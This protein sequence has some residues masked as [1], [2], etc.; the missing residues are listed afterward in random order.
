MPSEPKWLRNL[1]GHEY[2]DLP[3]SLSLRQTEVENADLKHLRGLRH[4][5][6]LQLERTRIGDPG[7]THIGRV[8]SLRELDLSETRITDTG[9]SHVRGL[10]HLRELDLDGTA[11]TDDGMQILSDVRSIQVVSLIGTDVTEE[12]VNRLTTAG[13][14]V[15]CVLNT[16]IA[17]LDESGEPREVL[18]AGEKV[19]LHGTFSV[20]LGAK[21]KG[22]SFVVSIVARLPGE[23]RVIV[24]QGFAR[25][26]QTSPTKYEL[27]K[28]LHLKSPKKAAVPGQLEVSFFGVDLCVEPLK[29]LSPARE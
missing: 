3:H 20:P 27:R 23:R 13:K 24:Q 8:R 14:Q 15:Y 2:F 18:T 25:P 1:I 17:A 29:M 4:L 10:P 9:L 16:H 22:T 6:E 11:V 5:R 12:G 7:M 28:V 19:Q 21:L 26:V